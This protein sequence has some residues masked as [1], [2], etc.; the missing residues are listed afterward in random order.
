M[1]IFDFFGRSDINRRLETYDAMPDAQLLDVRTAQ[2]YCE[3]HIPCSR[4]IP[5]QRIDEI[6]DMIPRKDVPLFVY[7]RSGSRSSQAAHILREMGYTHVENIGG[8]SAYLGRIER[9]NRLCQC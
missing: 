9:G 5:L 3:G 4:N 2:E 1:A 7:C 8:I 6:R